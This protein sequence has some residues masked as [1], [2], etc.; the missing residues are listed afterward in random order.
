[1]DPDKFIFTCDLCG[2]KF[3]HGL[4]RYEGHRLDLYGDLWCC[5]FC[6]EGNWD[7]WNAHYE[8]FLIAHLKKKGLPI[9]ERNEKGW[10]PRN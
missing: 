2:S 6:W 8:G 9:P 3:Q 5:S 1:M 4:H 10:L 7:G